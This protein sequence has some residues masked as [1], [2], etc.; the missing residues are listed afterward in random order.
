[1]GHGYGPKWSE[2]RT[3]KQLRYEWKRGCT[4]ESGV[5]RG[6]CDIE[7]IDRVEKMEEGKNILVKEMCLCQ[8]HCSSMDINP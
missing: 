4:N 2:A 5:V 3:V 6:W 8:D 7:G 1:M